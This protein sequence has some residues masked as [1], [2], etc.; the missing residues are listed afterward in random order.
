MVKIVECLHFNNPPFLQYNLRMCN[1]LCHCRIKTDM[2]ESVLIPQDSVTSPLLTQDQT[3]S[4]PPPTEPSYVAPGQEPDSDAPKRPLS[5][6]LY[7]PK[8]Y[9]EVYQDAFPDAF[10]PSRSDKISPTQATLAMASPLLTVPGQHDTPHDT[11]VLITKQDPVNFVNP[12]FL[13][14]IRIADGQETK[15]IRQLVSVFIVPTILMCLTCLSINTNCKAMV[16]GL[17]MVCKV[18]ATKTLIPSGE[19][20]QQT[21]ALNLV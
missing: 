19:H 3:S 15:T 16:C 2:E 11:S 13:P 12:Q 4:S 9:P 7:I 5:V 8:S 21:I 10:P 1:C 14:E 6:V 17:A 18:D 20:H